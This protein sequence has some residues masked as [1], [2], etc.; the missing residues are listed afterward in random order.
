MSL[1]HY[2]TEIENAIATEN[3]TY[4]RGALTA[5]KRQVESARDEQNNECMELAI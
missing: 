2:L 3:D 1:S 5:Y 4:R